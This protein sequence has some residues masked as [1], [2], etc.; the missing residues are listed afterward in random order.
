MSVDACNRLP[1]AVRLP[2]LTS[3]LNG[4]PQLIDIGEQ[5]CDR[6]AGA[7]RDAGLPPL[8]EELAAQARYVFACSDYAARTCQRWPQLWHE[9]RDSGHLQ[10]SLSDGVLARRLDAYPGVNRDWLLINRQRPPY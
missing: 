1:R 4:C 10:T 2:M 9:M 5:Q 3:M 7:L 8:S 6:F